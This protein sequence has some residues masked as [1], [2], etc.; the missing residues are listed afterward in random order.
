MSMTTVVFCL[1]KNKYSLF[2]RH[3]KVAGRINV[4]VCVSSVRG[5]VVT[6]TWW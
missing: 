3:D 1:N 5:A 6:G 4:R 2:Y